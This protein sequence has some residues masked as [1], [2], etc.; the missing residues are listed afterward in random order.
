MSDLENQYAKPVI[1]NLILSDKLTTLSAEQAASIAKFA[2]KCM[3]VADHGAI[4]SRPSFFPR[5]MRYKFA[6]SLE[7]PI[8]LQVWLSAFKEQGNGLFRAIYHD[9]PANAPDGFEIYSFTFG[10]GFFVFQSTAIKWL[11]SSAFA[12]LSLR[13]HPQWEKFSIQAWPTNNSIIWPP[14]KQL[15]IG[16]SED[17]CLRWKLLLPGR[18]FK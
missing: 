15:T 3:V 1:A 8:G 14:R 6:A 9:V 16:K 2:F 11:N 10:S 4:P 5:S 17:L 18:G 7:V 13:Q 12:P